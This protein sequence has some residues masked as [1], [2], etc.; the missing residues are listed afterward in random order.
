[1]IAQQSSYVV[2]IENRHTSIGTADE[3]RDDRDNARPDDHRQCKTVPGSPAL[4]GLGPVARGATKSPFLPVILGAGSAFSPGRAWLVE[5]VQ[6]P[7]TCQVTA[8][9]KQRFS[10]HSFLA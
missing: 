3:R 4:L 2:A 8:R 7:A 10:A 9:G 6:T 1:M 5:A